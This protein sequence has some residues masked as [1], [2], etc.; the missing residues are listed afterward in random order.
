MEIRKVNRVYRGRLS[1]KQKSFKGFHVIPTNPHILKRVF[2]NRGTV[3]VFPTTMRYRAMGK[4]VS[5]RWLCSKLKVKSVHFQSVTWVANMGRAI[6]VDDDSCFTE[7]KSLCEPELFPCSRLIT[8][9]EG[10][11]INMFHSG[12]CICLGKFFRRKETVA[13]VLLSLFNHIFV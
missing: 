13:S 3:L 5:K 10:T 9:N 12:K 6:P 8:I 11:K 1:S 7:F 2:P 4:R